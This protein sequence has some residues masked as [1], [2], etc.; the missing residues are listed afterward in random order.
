MRMASVG[1]WERGREG[2]ELGSSQ[3]FFRQSKWKLPLHETWTGSSKLIDRREIP[4]ATVQTSLTPHVVE[5]DYRELS[6]FLV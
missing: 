6:D 2:L 3:K 5:K 1:I 4:D